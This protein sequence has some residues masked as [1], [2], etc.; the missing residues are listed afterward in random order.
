MS[1]ITKGAGAG[2]AEEQSVRSVM[3]RL[4]TSFWSA[5]S[6][7][8]EP[9]FVA[10]VIDFEGLCTAHLSLV[11]GV[12]QQSVAVVPSPDAASTPGKSMYM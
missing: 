6:A 5:V 11:I 10:S 1:A 7:T 2:L 8:F 9:A 12:R 4:G 3:A